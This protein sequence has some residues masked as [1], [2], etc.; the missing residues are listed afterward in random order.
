[1]FIR[2][3]MYRWKDCYIFYT[4]VV[5]E[6]H[7]DSL[8]TSVMEETV[9]FSSLYSYS[10][11]WSIVLSHF[12]YRCGDRRPCGLPGHLSH[13]GNWRSWCGHNH[14]QW[15]YD[16]FTL[17]KFWYKFEIFYFSIWLCLSFGKPLLSKSCEKIYS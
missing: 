7:V 6:G 8:V 12:L 17:F 5:I 1:M 16:S 2:W 9:A 14:R 15:R 3:W 10:G 13:G 4:D 11:N